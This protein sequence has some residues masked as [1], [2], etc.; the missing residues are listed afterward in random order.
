LGCGVI[1]LSRSPLP[2]KEEFLEMNGS[3]IF[4]NKSTNRNVVL[5]YAF[6]AIRTIARIVCDLRIATNTIA[7]SRK[8]IR[9][10]RYTSDLAGGSSWAA[11]G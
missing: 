6:T 4:I 9:N 3:G 1:T 7:V 8:S 5:G 10:D 11:E 2:N